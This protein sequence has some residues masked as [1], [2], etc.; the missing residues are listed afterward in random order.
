MK[1]LSLFIVALATVTTAFGQAR[2]Y[3]KVNPGEK[4]TE[5]IPRADLFKYPTFQPGE[6]NFK[7]GR[8]GSANMNYNNLFSEIQ[9]IDPKG[10]TVSLNDE[11]TISYI[12]IGKDSFYFNNGFLESIGSYGKIRLAKRNLIGY[13]KKERLD[14]YGRQSSASVD[15]Y[16]TMSNGTYMKDLVAKEILFFSPYT[17]YYFGD[18]YNHYKPATKKS[19]ISMFGNYETQIEA[20]LKQQPIDFKNEN[21]LRKLSAFVQGL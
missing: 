14:G 10:D 8:V 2:K 20:F 5:S 18:I 6:V 19:L 3:F 17:E 1:L 13:V 4:I 11:K 9:F 12:T 7:N 15:T 21:D 16:N